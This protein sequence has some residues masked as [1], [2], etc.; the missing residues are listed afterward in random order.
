M[1]NY[2]HFSRLDSFVFESSIILSNYTVEEYINFQK[3][4]Y[5][6]I[7]DI[8]VKRTRKELCLIYVFGGCFNSIRIYKLSDFKK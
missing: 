6:G 1:N 3:S 5:K 4:V 7:Y 8:Y 2:E